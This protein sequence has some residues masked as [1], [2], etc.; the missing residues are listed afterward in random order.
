MAGTGILMDRVL[1]LAACDQ[2]D[3]LGAEQ[4]HLK[5]SNLP[6]IVNQ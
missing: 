3:V 2:S 5:L 1:Q 4:F 6:A